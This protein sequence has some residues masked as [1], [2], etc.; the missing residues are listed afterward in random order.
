MGCML[1]FISNGL[2]EKNKEF[3]DFSPEKK[4]FQSLHIY[5]L[6]MRR[7]K[8]IV[9]HSTISSPEPTFLLVSTEKREA[10][11]ATDIC[12]ILIGLAKQ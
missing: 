4:E 5:A 10:L 3:Q 7:V 2:K 8:D 12:S 6:L 11:A 9:S 1:A